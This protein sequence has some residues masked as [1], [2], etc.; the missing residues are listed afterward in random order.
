MKQAKSAVTEAEAPR[1]QAASDEKA[2]APLLKRKAISQQTYDTAVTLLRAAEAKLEGAEEAVKAAADELSYATVR[3]PMDA[4][5]F[6]KRVNVGDTVT[7]GQVLVTL[8][9]PQRMQ[10]VA[11]V[12]ESLAHESEGRAEHRREDREAQ[13]G[14]RRDD[15]RNRARG[16]GGQPQLPGESDRPLP[17]RRLLRHVRAHADSAGRRADLVVPGGAVRTVGQLELV[18]VVEKDRITR[19]GSAADSATCGS[20]TCWSRRRRS[21]FGPPRGRAG[22]AAGRG[23]AAGGGPWLSTP[24][25][26]I[27]EHGF[28]NRIVKI[29]LESNLSLILIILATVLGLAALGL[30]PREEDPQIVVPLA[31]VYVNF[32]GHSAEEVEQLVTTP[33]EKIL[34]QIDGVEYVYSMSRDDQAVITVRYYVGED[35]ERSL[36][37]LYKKIDEHRGHR[38]AR[39]DRLGRQAGR[40]RRRADRDAHAGR[41]RGRHDAPP[42]GRRSHRALAGVKDVSRA[43]VVG[44][45]PRV[46]QVYMDP[47]RMAAY[48]VSPLELQRAIRPPTSAD[49]RR[50]PQRGPT[51]PRRGRRAV[52]QAAAIPRSGRRRVRRP[53][54]VP[55]GRRRRRGRP[56]GSRQLRAPRLGTGAGI[57]ASMSSSRHGVGRARRQEADRRGQSHFR[58]KTNNRDSP[59]SAVTIAIAK[60]KGA[61]AVW[62]ANA[63]L[64]EAERLRGEIVPDDMELVVTRNY[65]LTANEKVNELV[66]AL[67]VAVL[68]VVALLTLGAGLARG[69]DRGRGGAG[70]LRADTGGQP[71]AG[72]HDQPRDA[73]RPDPV[74]GPAGRRSDRGRG[75][76]RPALRPAQEG[77]AADRAGGRGRDP[78]AADHRHAGRDRLL[79]AD[80]LHHRDDGAVH[81]ADGAERAG[82]DAH[83]DARGLHHHAVDGVP[84][85]AKA[86]STVAEAASDGHADHDPHDLDAVKQSRLYKL[87]YPLMA[88]LLHRGWWPGRSCWAWCC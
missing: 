70:R 39:R 75:E 50:F 58:A 49:R 77:H 56:G 1:A 61:N 59:Q 12:R 35:R 19:R 69:P 38:P 67:A 54:G 7:P 85:A 60:K 13:Q 40:D 43:Y 51:D 25:P 47:D 17:A 68:I 78:A 57:H 71:A 84:R 2:Y 37:K 65:G 28:T 83:V 32:P 5:V 42:R 55:Q 82:D 41:K 45:R 31:D 26:P 18:E 14:L 88:P 24:A 48:H 86:R 8:F 81:A 11:S 87:F 72:L 29:F 33:L 66:E 30:T 15:Q 6:D 9:D 27:Q 74:A 44:G 34:Y 79:P 4:I 52:H 76:H 64:R 80:V 46:I 20:A 22:R 16:P 36:V 23:C 73:L 10:L 21:A 63:V 53:A 62:V 3:A